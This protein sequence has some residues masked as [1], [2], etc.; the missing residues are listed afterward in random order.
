MIETTTYRIFH[1]KVLLFGEHSVLYGSKALAMPYLAV[2]AGLDFPVNDAEEPAIRESN[3]S[4]RAFAGYL[5]AISNKLTGMDVERFI[6]DIDHGLYFRS[7]IPANYGIGSSGAICAA[8]YDEYGPGN[9]DRDL[10][11]RS[12]GLNSV[13]D[14]LSTMESYFHGQSSGID[15]LC[16]F[17][18]QPMVVHGKGK[19]LPWLTYGKSDAGIRMFLLDTGR[20]SRTGD[21]VRGFGNKLMEPELMA[22]FN[23]QYMPL[24]DQIVDRFIQGNHTFDQLLRLSVFQS[25]L[26]QN[27]I[28]EDYYGVWQYGLQQRSYACKLCG[29]GGG[30]YILGFTENFEQAGNDLAGQFK[31]APIPLYLT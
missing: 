7:T 16:I 19:I 12:A 28:P 20:M 23:N 8:V 5:E 24:L 9:K 30:G 11:R 31:M 4:L 6:N 10:P 29:S 14:A 3:L 26:F 22:D 25:E 27:M 18:D 1:G 15:P 13:H 21:H 2:S 17:Y